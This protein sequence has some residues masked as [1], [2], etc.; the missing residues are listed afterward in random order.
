M[1]ITRCNLLIPTTGF[2][3]ANGG[4]TSQYRAYIYKTLN[5]GTSWVN[6]NSTLPLCRSIFMLDENN[7]Y[8]VGNDQFYL[9]NA[10]PGAIYR[11]NS[12]GNYWVKQISNTT[13]K[14]NDLY[15]LDLNNG[16]VIGDSGI[17]LKT[18]NGGESNFFQN[19]YI[20][21]KFN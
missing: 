8:A 1:D 6:V 19:L 7:G 9:G 15:F 21:Q 10:K 17:I 3:L 2:L 20:P 13:K 18:T 5:G 4:M 12:G 16:I 11:T 14:L